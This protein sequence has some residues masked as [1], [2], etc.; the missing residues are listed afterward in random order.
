MKKVAG[1]LL[2]FHLLLLLPRVGYS[3]K[4]VFSLRQLVDSADKHLPF[5]LQKRSL[6]QSAE[7]GVTEARHAFLPNLNIAEEVSVGSANDLAGPYLP[8]PGVMHTVS[9]SINATQNNTAVTGNLASVY[10]QYELVNFGLKGAR[11]AAARSFADWTRADLE[12]ERYLVAVEVARLYFSIQRLSAELA[13][14]SEDIRRHE[15]M[16]TISVALSGSGVIPGVDSSLARAALSRSRIA[17]NG[18]SGNLRNQRQ[19]LSYLCGIDPAA[20][21]VDTAGSRPSLEAGGPSDVSATHPLEDYFRKQQLQ[22]QAEQKLAARSYLPKV[23]VGAGGW[24]RGSAVQYGNVYGSVGDGLGFQRWN[25]LAGLGVTYD[26][27]NGIRRKDRMAVLGKQA[28]AA[29]F[30]LQQEQEALR[31][32][33]LQAEESIRTAAANLAELPAQLRAASEAYNQKLAQYQ[34]GIITLVDLVTASY[35]LLQAQ[36]Q[37][38]QTINQWKV[39]RLEKAA[40]EGTLPQFLQSVN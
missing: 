26:L 27:F 5:L 32:Q 35:E 24:I 11:T 19:Q 3:Q 17:F 38:I 2:R 6:V 36:T 34:A 22:Y 33:R 9:G 12:K 39:A 7:A 31:N 1:R 21:A 20:I 30:A 15:T 16:Y 10:A 4:A 29:G 37:Y 28:E 40:A 8:L 23:T 25:Y 14:D 13:V 18:I